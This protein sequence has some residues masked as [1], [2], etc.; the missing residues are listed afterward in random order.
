VVTPIVW[1]EVESPDPEAFQEF[2]TSLSGWAFR[3]AFQETDL[4]ADYWVVRAGD[5]SIGGLQRGG[6]RP[7]TGVRLYLQVTDLEATLGRA[8]ALGATIERRRTE[9]GGDDRW[10]AT[11]LDPTGVSFGL[12]TENPPIRTRVRLRPATTAEIPDL[13]RITAEAYGHYVALIGR[14]PAPMLADLA[15]PVRDQDVW[16]ALEGDEVLGLIVMATGPEELHVDNIAVL[17]ANQGHGI[18]ATLLDLAEARA[19]RHGLGAVTLFTNQA[20]VENLA[21]YARRGFSETDRRHE[22][23]FARVH[24]RKILP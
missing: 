6:A 1:W 15:G 3:P 7:R 5:E 13:E 2:H 24:L 10:F 23:G 8:R 16:V 9:L 20:M 21:W 17:P 12:W 22:E 14:P 19:A 11:F 18:G 4:D